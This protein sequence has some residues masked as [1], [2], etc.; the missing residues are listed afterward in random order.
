MNLALAQPDERI[1]GRDGR[2]R[3]NG[4]ISEYAVKLVAI[5]GGI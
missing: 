1:S 2:A 3:R 4:L 5:R